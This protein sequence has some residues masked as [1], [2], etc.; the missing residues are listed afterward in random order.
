M[1]KFLGIDCGA[2]NLRIGIF[3]G[4]GNLLNKWKI[5]SPLKTNPNQFAQIVKDQIGE[6]KIESIGVGVPGPLDLETGSILPS[7]NLGNTKPIEVTRQFEAVFD[8]KIYLDRDTNVALL[9]EAWKGA[10]VGLKDVIM[11]TLGSGVGGAIMTNGQIEHGESGKAGELGHMII[12]VKKV[13][14]CGLGHD[15]CLEALINSTQDLDELGTYLGLGL[16]NIV[17]I[18]NPE[19]IIIGGG[20]INMGDFLSKAKEVMKEKGMKPAIDEVSVEY[21]KLKDDSGVYGAAKL[22]LDSK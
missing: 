12:G 5:N 10:A 6:E 14:V 8:I 1:S 9:G 17:N 3:D 4:Q 16:A 20:K 11:L 19:K 15:S 21:A 13:P 22:C 18:F 7:A 2:T